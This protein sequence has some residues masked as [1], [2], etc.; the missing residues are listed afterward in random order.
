MSF[1]AIKI[2]SD[3]VE[4]GGNNLV[5]EVDKLVG[6]A[7]DL[8]IQRG[9]AF[10]PVWVRTSG[11]SARNFAVIA[12]ISLLRAVLIGSR[13]SGAVFDFVAEAMIDLFRVA[14]GC[15]TNSRHSKVEKKFVY[16]F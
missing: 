15:T 16:L 7:A 9:L 2:E 8:G 4:R 14:I 6:L 10:I 13:F 1:E 12:A 11:N 3:I 5:L